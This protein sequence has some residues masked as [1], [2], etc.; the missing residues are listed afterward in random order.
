MPGPELERG[1]RTAQA[2]SPR[3]LTDGERWTAEALGALRAGNYRPAAW[4]RFIRASLERSRSSRL[5]R[6][7]LARQAR[8]WATIGAA[9]WLTACTLLRRPRGPRPPLI[10]GLIWWW[11]VW[12]MLDW[13][14]GMAEGGDGVPR[15]RLSPA[16][17]AT[18]TRFWLVPLTVAV[19]RA[20]RGLAATIA[21]GGLT[22]ACDGQLARRHGRT[23]LGRDLDTTADLCFL[24]A[25]SISLHAAGRLPSSAAWTLGARHAL[26]VAL[27]SGAVFARARRP[28]IRA[29][30]AGSA[31]RIGG[32]ALCA[33]DRR[34]VGTFVLVAG[35]LTPPRSTMPN[36][37][38]A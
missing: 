13:H 30:P 22:D 34:R 31:L 3:P 20:P 7:Q 23:R 11:T 15:R 1:A 9:G 25:A 6:P 37:S 10:G 5:A 32:L 12:R 8:R 38:P 29:R 33:C 2:Y 28:A 4:S 24:T 36:L 27:A 17:A 35:C 26:G 18:L 14:L 21:I 16:D 19:R